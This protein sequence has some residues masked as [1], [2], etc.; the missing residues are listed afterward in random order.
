[1]VHRCSRNVCVCRNSVGSGSRKESE[2]KH[3]L[4]IIPSNPTMEL[5]TQVVEAPGGAVELK[6]L[7]RMV[8]GF[9]EPVVNLDDYNGQPA[10]AWCNEDGRSK[11][12]PFNHRATELWRKC[13]GEG[14]FRYEPKLYGDVVI[15]QIAP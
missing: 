7:Q 10:I 15:E 11:N 5:S 14:P 3:L 2:M 8:D 12:L 1:M 13:L 4:T 6:L 9:I